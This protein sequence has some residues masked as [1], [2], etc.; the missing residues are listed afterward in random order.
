MII[1]AFSNKTS[2]II[3][4][5]LCRRLK[6]VAPIV[7]RDDKLI[8]FQ[9]IKRGHIEKVVLQMRDIKILRAHGWEFI[10]IDG[11]TVPPNFNP[12]TAY[13]CVD[14]TKR[15]IGVHDWRI[16]TPHGLYKRLTRN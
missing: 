16:Q 15:A 3:P 11:A 5:I 14:L 8:L 10:Y 2:K 4:N 6:H 13:S 12:Y 9:F 1:I 7:P